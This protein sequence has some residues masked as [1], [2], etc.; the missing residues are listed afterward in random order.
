MKPITHDLTAKT[1]NRTQPLCCYCTIFLL[2]KDSKSFLSDKPFYIFFY[3]T[4]FILYSIR[5][6]FIIILVLHIQLLFRKTSFSFALFFF[7]T[8]VF[9]RNVDCD[10]GHLFPNSEKQ[11]VESFLYSLLKRVTFHGFSVFYT[12][13]ICFFGIDTLLLYLNCQF[14][15]RTGK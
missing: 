6:L 1:P 9:G 10:L 8:G 11:A 12:I 14:I 15:F 2:L 5:S 7:L 13:I 4:F 3:P